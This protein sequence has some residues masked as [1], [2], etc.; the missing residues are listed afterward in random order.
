MIARAI[1][2]KNLAIRPV[3]K[4]GNC[5]SPYLYVLEIGPQECKTRYDGNEKEL[6]KVA[7]NFLWE[8]SLRYEKDN[9]R[10]KGVTDDPEKQV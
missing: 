10:C 1:A 8:P 9:Q 2:A 3:E 7:L 5:T 4:I 6:H